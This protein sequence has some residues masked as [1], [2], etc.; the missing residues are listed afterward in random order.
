MGSW[1]WGSPVS[2]PRMRLQ[3]WTRP[4]A[5]GA[6]ILYPSGPLRVLCLLSLGPPASVEQWTDISSLPLGIPCWPWRTA[7][8]SCLP[9]SLGLCN[10]FF[11]CQRGPVV[12][13]TR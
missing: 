5:P 3:P 11:L 7:V 6:L 2:S 10:P 4:S 12:E 8:W 1:P 13:G 9:L